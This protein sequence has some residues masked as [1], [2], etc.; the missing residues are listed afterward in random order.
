M[1]RLAK[2]LQ[3]NE[4]FKGHICTLLTTTTSPLISESGAQRSS[5]SQFPTCSNP[6]TWKCDQTEPFRLSH[7]LALREVNFRSHLGNYHQSPAYQGNKN[8]R[9]AGKPTLLPSH[10]MGFY[11]QVYAKK[12]QEK[13]KLKLTGRIRGHGLSPEVPHTRLP[14][15]LPRTPKA[16]ASSPATH[17]PS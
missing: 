10:P 17:L 3:S 1:K 6:E 14:Q 11:S 16:A 12:Q 4:A 15:T 13:L 9:R 5:R 2:K 7:C 8:T